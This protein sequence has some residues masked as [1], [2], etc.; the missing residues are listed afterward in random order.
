MNGHV[1]MNAARGLRL[2]SGARVFPTHAP[3]P[4]TP[5]VDPPEALCSYADMK[6]A[7]CALHKDVR[8]VKVVS[9]QMTPPD[10]GAGRWFPM[11]GGKRTQIAP[12]EVDRACAFIEAVPAG[13]A[14]LLH[15]YHGLNRTLLVLAALYL[16]AQQATVQDALHRVRQIRPP[17]IIRAE[18][19][20]ALVRWWNAK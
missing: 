3:G 4:R 8:T 14:V 12:E 1:Q 18:T 6:Q 9:L 19:V 17:G 11:Q 5:F 7:V 20:D 16:R 2:P 15:C 10:E 13:T